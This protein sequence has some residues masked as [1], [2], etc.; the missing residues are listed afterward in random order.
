[1]AGEAGHGSQVRYE[2]GEKPPV[3]LAAALGAQTVALI[4]AGI[5]LTPIIVL[6]AAGVAD[7]FGPWAVFMALIVSGLI[8]VV[9]GV[10]L[11]RIGAGYVL[12]MGTSGAFMS[13]SVTAI[14][15]GSIALLMTLIVASSLLQFPLAANLGLLRKIIT[16]AVGGTTIML[17]SVTI[18]PIAYAMLQQV[19][20]APDGSP[21]DLSG[22]AISAGVTFAI[23]IAVSLFGRRSLRLWSPLFG[24]IVGSAVASFFG[25]LDLSKVAGAAWIG[26]PDWNWPGL[27]LSFGPVFWQLLPAFLIVTLVGAIETFGDGIA[28]QRSSWRTPRAVDFRSVQGAVFADGAGNLLSGLG[29]TLPNT[30][31]STSIAVVDMTGVAARSIAVWGGSIMVCLAFSPKLAQLLLTVPSPVA[32]AYIVVLLVLLF[33]HGINLVMQDGLT[34]ENSLVV[35]LGFWLG[36][37]F[38]QKAL[39]YDLMPSWMASLLSNGMTSGTIAAI[40]LTLLLRLKTGQ[41]Q[42]IEA[43]LVPASLKPLH[44]FAQR[45]AVDAGWD[46]PASNRLQLAVEELFL[47][48]LD[49]KKGEGAGRLRIEARR[50]AETIVLD[51]VAGPQGANLE[52]E[53]PRQ[54]QRE[55][56]AED[57]L[58]YRILNS[59][60]D[61]LRHQQYHGIEF[62]TLRLSSRPL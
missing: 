28:I 36:V 23:I 12:F 48:L 7:E 15:E 45:L 49:Q 32:G 47:V 31:Y 26:V 20:A 30:T 29:G 1:M 43:P 41:R 54:A 62:L 5:V 10:K 37:G 33:M 25:L 53:L 50:E 56:D 3:Q 58:S 39:F 11:W 40:V 59:I 6:R 21:G 52:D 57:A 38:Q 51:I 18:M 34:F 42:R 35:G 14:V 17:I 22:A 60:V 27:D 19:P 46:R 2:A 16:P 24:L 61:D 4:V 8:T 55:P 44:D 13:V 9:Q